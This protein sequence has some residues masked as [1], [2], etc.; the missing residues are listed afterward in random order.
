MEPRDEEDHWLAGSDKGHQPQKRERERAQPSR[1]SERSHQISH[2]TSRGGGAGQDRRDIRDLAMIVVP[3]TQHAPRTGPQAHC[4]LQLA[5]AWPN[6]PMADVLGIPAAAFGQ[7]DDV[8][9]Y[10]DFIATAATCQLLHGMP[11]GIPRRA[12]HQGMD[13]RWIPTQF[14]L[15]RAA[16]LDEDA[17]VD[18]IQST[19]A[20][21]GVFSGDLVAGLHLGVT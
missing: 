11:V 3:P 19:Q 13:P 18:L 5:L 2:G 21:D 20:A 9:G 17:P 12:V 7:C 10:I 16:R 4:A 8:T 14:L 1:P 15:H 6:Q